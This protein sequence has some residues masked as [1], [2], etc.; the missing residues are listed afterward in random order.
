MCSPHQD[1]WIIARKEWWM[2]AHQEDTQ[3]IHMCSSIARLITINQSWVSSREL[4]HCIKLPLCRQPSASA[5]LIFAHGGAKTM[6]ELRA[7][8]F[9][10]GQNR[11][12]DNGER[13]YAHVY[14][15]ILHHNTQ[16]GNYYYTAL[17]AN[18]TTS[19][20]GNLRHCLYSELRI[21]ILNNHACAEIFIVIFIFLV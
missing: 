13:V 11:A 9:W 4:Q 15:R 18:G 10:V 17:N 8:S 20:Q 7:T 21:V 12:A 2:V 3:L 6:A 14:K 1:W 16:S 5:E 19:L